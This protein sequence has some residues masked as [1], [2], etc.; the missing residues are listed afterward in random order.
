MSSVADAGHVQT[1]PSRLPMITMHGIPMSAPMDMPGSGMHYSGYIN[2]AQSHYGGSTMSLEEQMDSA[3]INHQAAFNP[4]TFD[5]MDFPVFDPSFDHMGAAPMSPLSPII[6]S[7][8][9]DEPNAGL[10]SFDDSLDMEAILVNTHSAPWNPTIPR[11]DPNANSRSLQIP[12]Q[13]KHQFMSLPNN[14]GG[15]SFDSAYVSQPH[16][17]TM[18]FVSAPSAAMYSCND[19]ESEIYE[20]PAKKARSGEKKF[21]CDLPGEHRT[22]DFA[23]IHDL[24]RHQRSTHGIKPKHSTGHYYRCK[25][26]ECRNK[27]KTWD[28]KDNFRS[29]IVRKHFHGRSD[30][31]NKNQ[32]DEL[33]RSSQVELSE[34]DIRTIFAQKQKAKVISRHTASKRRARKSSSRLDTDAANKVRGSIGSLSGNTSAVASAVDDNEYSNFPG[35]DVMFSPELDGFGDM[36]PISPQMVAYAIGSGVR[37]EMPRGDSSSSND[38]W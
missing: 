2:P 29:H 5:D 15:F 22:R 33:V 26:K 24:E 1:V 13:P 3:T 23:N 16:A 12:G 14:F 6:T 4:S 7:T 35:N 28:R 34:H 19:D 21:H 25:S 20:R 10:D 31:R 11:S 38:F 37:P 36:T 17:D 27:P 18:S 8:P 9:A 32:I 30:D